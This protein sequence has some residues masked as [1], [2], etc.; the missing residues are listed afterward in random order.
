MS[1]RAR[2]SRRRWPTMAALFVVGAALGA[3]GA[4]AIGRRR[5]SNGDDL[6]SIV[7]PAGG[8]PLLGSI[9]PDAEPN[10]AGTRTPEP[11]APMSPAVPMSA[12]DGSS[13]T[14]SPPTGA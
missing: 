10:D 7:D 12:A 14:T 2:T 4:T 13:A 9:H 11:A 6:A 3:A 1:R 8:E 5:Q